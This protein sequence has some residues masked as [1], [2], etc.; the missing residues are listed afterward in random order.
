MDFKDYTQSDYIK[1]LATTLNEGD[2]AAR[3]EWLSGLGKADM[4]K[5]FEL[6]EDNLSPQYFVDEDKNQLTEKIHYG[7]NSL[8]MFNNFQK[9]F[10]Y[11]DENSQKQILGYNH[12]SMAWIT[13]PGYFNVLSSK[14]G[15]SSCVIDYNHIPEKTCSNWPEIEDNNG[16][17]KSLV[18]GGMQD[19]MKKISENVS[20]GRAVI[21]G[22][23]TSNYFIL[24]K[25]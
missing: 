16:F 3:M 14:E 4:V 23:I 21:K 9:R 8:P 15:L 5:L 20:I 13:G 2:H 7:K 25:E 1:K 17:P 19:Y 11:L 12:Q 24:I 18:Y 6:A 10:A 22:K